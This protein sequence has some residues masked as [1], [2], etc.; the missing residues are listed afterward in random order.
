MMPSAT[1]A[2]DIFDP[3]GSAQSATPL[4]PGQ[5]NSLSVCPGQDDYYQLSLQSGD[6]V[7]A[8][9]V[10]NASEGAV[11][12]DVIDSTGATIG[13]GMASGSS[14][15]AQLTAAAQGD[16]FLRVYLASDAGSTPGDRYSLSVSLTN[17]PPAAQCA[18]DAYDP[19]DSQATAAPIAPGTYDNLTVCTQEDD[20][21]AVQVH[22]GDTISV[23]LSFSNAEGD[24]DLG[25]LDGT[26]TLVAISDGTTNTESVSY[27]AATDDIYAVH[28]Y[29][30]QDL[31][32]TPGNGYSM[33][34]DVASGAQ[35]MCPEDAFDPNSSPQTAP[36]I[37]LGSYP[38]L[39]V[40]PGAD[41]Y[42]A[43]QLAAGQTLQ[44]DLAFIN[45]EGDI[46][47][48]LLD[49]TGTV[50]ALSNGST[51]GE[52]ITYSVPT[53]GYYF[54]WVYLYADGGMTP[55]NSYDMSLSA[56]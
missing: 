1:C 11:G 29:L 41:D 24:I 19:N 54:V 51:D 8:T 12:L 22:A 28:V 44:A 13:T 27:T 21:F 23:S 15:N 2:T 3:N 16:Y 53:D 10:F 6:A 52:S 7:D 56:Y 40:C 34:V 48:G 26:G 17:Q 47:L 33:T 50:V 30:Y 43:V 55:G 4:T 35:A 20:Y 39:S 25:L 42:F 49:D 38:G 32:T 31:G 45:A 9:V 5:Y 18:P 46:D 37:S 14:V 36:L